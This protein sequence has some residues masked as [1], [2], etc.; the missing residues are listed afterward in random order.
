VG[1]VTPSRKAGE[2]KGKGTRTA[3][4]ISGSLSKQKGSRSCYLV[5]RCFT[6]NE[7]LP[8]TWD[9]WN[10][11]ETGEGDEEWTFFSCIRAGPQKKEETNTGQ[12]APSWERDNAL[13]REG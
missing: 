13:Q 12:P 11:K 4:A 7:N 1:V 2:R 10:R 3:S 6:E 9:C 8:S 5:L